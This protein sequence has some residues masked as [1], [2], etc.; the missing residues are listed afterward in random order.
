MTG[1]PYTLHRRQI[2]PL[3]LFGR[4]A[5]YGA[6]SL[7]VFLLLGIL[8]Y[9]FWRGSRTVNVDFL[10]SVTS[11]LKQTVGI[12]GNLVNTLYIA[13]LTLLVAMPVGVGAAVYLDE[14]MSEGRGK[15][16][17]EWAIE[18]LAGVP[19][20]VF[21]LFGM[22]FFG[23]VLHMGYSLLNGA[24]TL[25]CMVLPLVVRNTQEALRAVPAE[26]RWG[27]LGVGASRWHMVRTVL[28]PAA[29]PGIV[30]GMILAL[31][32]IVGES[33]ALLFTAGS[34]RFL[35]GLGRGIYRDLQ[36]LAGKV[37]CSGGTIAVELYL[38]MQSGRYEVAFGAAC[39][40]LVLVFIMQVLL[41]AVAG[42][43]RRDE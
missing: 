27:A 22:A 42:K 26:Y 41:R 1:N 3:E 43:G 18:I 16:L 29:R 5:I 28:L 14:Y 4:A 38:Q 19:S 7:S 8:C 31:G 33:A 13:I 32:R 17:V 23:G 20:V 15:A 35:P 6:S 36:A 10:T 37:A 12:G 11:A 39:V 9:I 34:G 24:L 30:T 2:R 25:C 40:L 21:G